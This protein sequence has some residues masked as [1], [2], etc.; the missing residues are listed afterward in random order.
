MLKLCQL[1][2]KPRESMKKKVSRKVQRLMGEDHGLK[3]LQ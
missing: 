2:A 3:S 1:A